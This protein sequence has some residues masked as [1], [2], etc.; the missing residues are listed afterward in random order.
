MNEAIAQHQQGVS[1]PSMAPAVARLS[2]EPGDKVMF[3]SGGPSMTVIDIGIHSA[4]VWC[5]WMHQGALVESSFAA[6]TLRTDPRSS[7]QQP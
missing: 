7:C 2:F 3:A 5:Q 1:I 4:R 6:Q